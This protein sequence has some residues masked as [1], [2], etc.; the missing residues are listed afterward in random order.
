MGPS[1]LIGV[2]GP[3]AA[4]V[5]LVATVFTEHKQLTVLYLALAY[6]CSDF[7]LPSGL[8]RLP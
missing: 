6:G 3:G 1:L 4:A 8:G 2:I 5:F 7:A